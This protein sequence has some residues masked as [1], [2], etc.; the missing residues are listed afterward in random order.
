[1][2]LKIASSVLLL[3]CLAA[4]NARAA[5]EA[6]PVVELTATSTNLVVTEE[7]TVMVRLW[8]PPLKDELAKHLVVL[9]GRTHRADDLGLLLGELTNLVHCA[10][11]PRVLSTY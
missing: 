1:M 2:K 8:M 9:G 6:K 5:G 3:A 7:T 10:P 11:I 4:W